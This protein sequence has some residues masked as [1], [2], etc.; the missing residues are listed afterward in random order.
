MDGTQ[1]FPEYAVDVFTLG[2]DRLFPRH[3]AVIIN[4]IL[5]IRMKITGDGFNFFLVYKGPSIPLATI[6]ALLAFKNV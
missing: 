6:T 2:Q 5:W 4:K 3:L 1:T